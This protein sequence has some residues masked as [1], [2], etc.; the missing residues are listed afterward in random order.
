MERSRFIVGLAL[1]AIAALLFLFGEGDYYTPGAI[2]LGVLGLVLVAISR[3]K[4]G[5]HI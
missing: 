3:R 5:R 4:P 2:S 1:I